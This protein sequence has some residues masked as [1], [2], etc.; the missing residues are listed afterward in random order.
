MTACSAAESSAESPKPSR[1]SSR[2]SPTGERQPGVTIGQV[3]TPTKVRSRCESLSR[4]PFRAW[5]LRCQYAQAPMD[6]SGRHPGPAD[7]ERRTTARWRL[8]DSVNR[9]QERGDARSDARWGAGE[10][11]LLVSHVRVPSTRH[12]GSFTI[13]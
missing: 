6:Q 12:S 8:Y 2:Y 10:D 9:R 11:E 3:S 1:G 7:Q 13:A 5:S 4:P